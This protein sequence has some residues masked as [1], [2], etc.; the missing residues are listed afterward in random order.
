MQLDYVDLVYAHRSDNCTPME[1]IVRAFN[2]LIENGK[3]LYWGTSEWSAEQ[4]SDAH[5]VA[6]RLNLIAPVM[7]Q[8]QYNMF[9]RDRFER[10]YAPLYKKY[11]LGTTIWSAL[12][13]GIRK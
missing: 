9:C 12:A 7:E 3:A 5:R 8:P 13:S 10:E 1:E 6:E 11:K 2:F 4:I